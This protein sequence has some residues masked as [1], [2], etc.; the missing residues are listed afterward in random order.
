M[1][2]E[3]DSR[4][5]LVQ[6]NQAV[7]C[8]ILSITLSLAL[9]MNTFLGHRRAL[10]QAHNQILV[11]QQNITNVQNALKNNESA[12][13]QTQNALK[14]AQKALAHAEAAKRQGT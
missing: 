5:L 7:A 1:S 11:L 3:L 12:L 13:V 4:R 9:I 2:A 6:R 10:V 8:A 14:A